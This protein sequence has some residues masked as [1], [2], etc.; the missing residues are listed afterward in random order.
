MRLDLTSAVFLGSKSR[1]TR[2]HVLLS[3]NFFRLEDQVPVFIFARNQIT[4]S[5]SQSYI[6]TDYQWDNFSWRQ[7]PTSGP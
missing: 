1:R 5:R 2:D 4:A 3:R 7:A 6:T